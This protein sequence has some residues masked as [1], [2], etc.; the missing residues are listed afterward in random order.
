MK[1]SGDEQRCVYFAR[2]KP[3]YET[4]LSSEALQ[5]LPCWNDQEMTR[6][7]SCPIRHY[8]CESH[9]RRHTCEEGNFMQAIN[10]V[11]SGLS[12]V[13]EAISL[14][15]LNTMNG[16]T[17]NSVLTGYAFCVMI[18]PAEI[19]QRLGEFNFPNYVGDHCFQELINDLNKTVNK[20]QVEKRVQY[21]AM[22]C[23]AVNE[24]IHSYFSSIPRIILLSHV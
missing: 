7:Y 19:F 16:N 17:R 10:A 1:R 22:R 18:Q 24:T 6:L 12:V 21:N 9:Y 14:E 5:C 15:A 20:A 8:L 13:P 2:N 11:T 3:C 23:D 4:A